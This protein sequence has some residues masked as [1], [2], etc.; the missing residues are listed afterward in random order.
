MHNNEFRIHCIGIGEDANKDLIV[1]CSKAGKGKIHFINNSSNLK[2]QIFE[3]LNDYTKEYINNYNFKINNKYY[4]LKPINKITYDEESLNYFFIQKGNE[5]NDI[6]IKFNWENLN[7]KFNEDL[8]FKLNDIIILPK[9]EELS[10]LI[11]G[12]ILKYNII[13]SIEKQ[14]EFSKKFQVLS[15]YTTLYAEI[16]GDKPIENKM[17]TL[18]QKYSIPSK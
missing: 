6:N 11:I 12:L 15:K 13:N 9:E 4:E 10:K 17:N 18:I 7:R 8:T 1:K 5:E 16:E 3:I 2:T 14:M